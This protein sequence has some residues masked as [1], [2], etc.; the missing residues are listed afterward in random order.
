M[1]LDAYTLWTIVLDGLGLCLCIAALV[2]ARRI[3]TAAAPPVR[4]FQQDV[5]REA[6]RQRLA[7][8]FAAIAD[9]VDAE[10]RSLEA[11]WEPG[12]GPE[13]VPVVAPR[14][15]GGSSPSVSG[16]ASGAGDVE[17]TIEEMA[18]RGMGV[19]A[20]AAAIQRPRA[21]VALSLKLRRRGAIA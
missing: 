17:S 11:L 3:G 5:D 21:E 6:V 15:R 12:A 7:A 18:D 20:I 9:R 4:A 19:E 16:T 13:T 10:R 14:P 8:A 1:S 2:A